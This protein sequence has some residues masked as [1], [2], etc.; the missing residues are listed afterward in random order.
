M[1]VCVRVSI[2]I[3][4]RVF[5]NWEVRVK[6]T[7][8]YFSRHRDGVES[9]MLFKLEWPRRRETKTHSSSNCFLFLQ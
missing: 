9:P 1:C 6:L 8:S 4:A 7:R 5:L 2:Y 3:R